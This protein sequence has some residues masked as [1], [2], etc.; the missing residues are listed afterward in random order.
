M[1]TK[2]LE[3]E[4]ELEGE[5]EFMIEFKDNF[6]IEVKEKQDEIDQLRG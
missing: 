6:D 4:M 2:L 3:V 5:K 1:E